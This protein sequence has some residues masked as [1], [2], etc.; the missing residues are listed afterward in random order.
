M[1]TSDDDDDADVPPDYNDA[2]DDVSSYTWQSSM[3]AEMIA[4]PTVAGDVATGNTGLWT[5]VFIGIVT[6][7]PPYTAAVD[8]STGRYTNIEFTHL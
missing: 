8:A 5:R 1:V 3:R 2:V 7:P 6:E 4:G